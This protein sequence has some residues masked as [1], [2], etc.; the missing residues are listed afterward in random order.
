MGVAVIW[1]IDPDTRTARQCVGDA[2]TSTAHL[3][4]PGTPIELSLEELFLE[5]D[6]F[7]SLG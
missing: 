7:P 3:R 5:L 2:W 1:I 6:K 4:V